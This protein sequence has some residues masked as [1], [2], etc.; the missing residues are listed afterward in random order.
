M[1]C[2]TTRQTCWLINSN[3]LLILPV[4]KRPNKL[5]LFRLSIAAVLIFSYRFGLTKLF[6]FHV[7]FRL[8]VVVRG[9]YLREWSSQ[10]FYSHVYFVDCLWH[11]LDVSMNKKTHHDNEKSRILSKQAIKIIWD[12]N[13]RTTCV[14]LVKKTKTILTFSHN[15]KMTQFTSGPNAERQKFSR[16]SCAV[17]FRAFPGTPDV[18]VA[19]PVVFA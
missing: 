12:C 10:S 13:K 7:I 1:F 3:K 5:Y 2:W 6:D 8:K 17:E 14:N 19:V 15:A 18:P 16:L 11:R 4:L 9:V